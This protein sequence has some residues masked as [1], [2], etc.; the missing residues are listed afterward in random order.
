MDY[1]EYPPTPR[2]APYVDR[3]WT[4]AGSADELGGASQPVLP[5]GRPELVMHFG[6]GF[7]RLTLDGVAARQAHVIMA[8]QLSG[9]L[10]LRPLGRIAVL[11]VRFQPFGAA[12]FVRVPQQEL[13]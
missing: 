1:R 4:L 9:Q 10:L 2:L 6:D 8:G 3:L 13:S 11:G 5:D 12:A 7:E